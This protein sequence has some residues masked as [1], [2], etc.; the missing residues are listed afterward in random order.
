M[1]D[2]ENNFKFWDDLFHVLIRILIRLEV[3]PSYP[4]AHLMTRLTYV[5]IHRPARS[6]AEL[7]VGEHRTTRGCPVTLTMLEAQLCVFPEDLIGQWSP[8]GN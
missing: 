1:L 2:D 5:R 8:D 4:H 6:A 3:S 7:A